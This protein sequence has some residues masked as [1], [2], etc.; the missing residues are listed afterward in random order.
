M[1]YRDARSDAKEDA[2][3][4][5]ICSAPRPATIFPMYSPRVGY[6]G[7]HCIAGEFPRVNPS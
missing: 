5:A 4:G 3:H 2:T 1:D 7:P 6:K